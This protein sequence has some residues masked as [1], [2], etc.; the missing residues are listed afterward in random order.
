MYSNDLPGGNGNRC[1]GCV[2]AL[3]R[4]LPRC[5]VYRRTVACR[6][7]QPKSAGHAIASWS[8]FSKA[9]R[10]IAEL[11]FLPRSA[12]ALADSQSHRQRCC[13]ITITVSNRLAASPSLGC[14]RGHLPG[15]GRRAPLQTASGPRRVNLVE[16]AGPMSLLLPMAYNEAGFQH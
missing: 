11:S 2:P 5:Q 14:C 3:F 4:Y 10:E 15:L 6:R 16:R 12:I 7:R 9:F 13:G 1:P 8:R